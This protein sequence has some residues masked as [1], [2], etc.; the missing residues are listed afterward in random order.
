MTTTAHQTG[1]VGPSG[2]EFPY[3][4]DL[5]PSGRLFGGRAG[6]S[7]LGLS[8]RLLCP[9]PAPGRREIMRRGRRSGSWRRRAGDA[10]VRVTLL[11]PF[12]IRLGE[13]SAG[14]WYR[15]PAKRLCE[16]VMV[17]PGLRVGRE[18]ARELLFADLGA[19][20]LGQRPVPGAVI[21]P[22]GPFRAGRRGRRAAASRPGPHLVLGRRSPRH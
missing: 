6:G 21:G 9:A 16:L 8:A 5:R 1:F 11:G 12:T 22:G 3:A 14:P 10:R 17:S 20:R 15:P 4:T 13:R 18:V 2:T 19:G 7:T